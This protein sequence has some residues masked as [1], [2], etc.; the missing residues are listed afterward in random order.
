MAV[1]LG[2][3]S[4]H[5][6]SSISIIY[7][8]VVAFALSEERVG[9]RIKHTN[10]FPLNA[11]KAGL[12]FCN[13]KLSD[14]DYIALGGDSKAN[15]ANKL[16]YGIGASVSSAKSALQSLKRR[17]QQSRFSIISQINS[18]NYQEDFGSLRANIEVIAVEHHLCHIASTYFT[19]G[20]EE[21]VAGFSYDGSGD[22]VSMMVAQCD[23]GKIKVLKK[24]YL[25]HS[26]G[27]FYTG[28]CQYLGFDRFGEEYKV[29][30]LSPYGEDEFSDRVK[31]LIEPSNRQNWFNLNKN[32]FNMHSGGT[33][34]SSNH[35]LEMGRIYSD[36]LANQ[37]GI[38]ARD[39][40]EEIDQSHKNLAK[41]VQ[42]RFEEVAL[43]AINRAL[44]ASQ[45]TN[46]V[47]AGGCA[48]NGV[49]NGKILSKGI[50]EKVWL[51]PASS[52][53]GIS[54]GAA[55]WV[56]N[57]KLARL[58]FKMSNPYLGPS[59]GET[60]KNILA[61]TSKYFRFKLPDKSKKYELAAHLIAR[62]YVVG[63][64]SGRSELGA[65]ALGNRSIFAN[66]LDLKMRDV[67]N[68][69]I[70]K[71]EGFR[72]FAP[73]VLDEDQGIYFEQKLESPFMTF[74]VNVRPEWRNKLPA[75]THVDGTARVQTVV[76][77]S[78]SELWELLSA[79]KSQTGVGMLLNTSF[80]E[81][82][83]IVQ[84]G[85]EAHRCFERTDLDCL[86]LDNHFFSKM[87]IDEF[88]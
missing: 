84:T 54:L 34:G 11:L 67:I 80:N 32:F 68:A 25:P 29:M 57:Q 24:Q 72:P 77:N 63:W 13:L 65:R 37:I 22:F 58:H 30:G 14:I 47:M 82:E 21:R 1:V 31:T 28:M 87:P 7:D 15:F 78:S 9:Q 51:G 49:V 3:N 53:D 73:S 38:V 10:F 5:P 66:P 12:A 26:M 83:P 64:C 41:S 55:L 74:V 20:L 50:A 17:Q 76:K 60:E 81:N 43:S 86:F 88:T 33:A 35:N 62:G 56:Q 71:R 27:F 69:K 16:A 61:K 23:G 85:V 40:S 4:Y 6:D 19:S 59:V 46:L 18:I 48:L 2:I 44:I 70:K 39:R 8:G 42:L 79:V 52:D 75:I 36:A 45:S